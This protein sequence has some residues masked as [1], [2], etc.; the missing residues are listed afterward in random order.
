MHVSPNTVLREFLR[1][2]S[3]RPLRNVGRYLASRWP[4]SVPVRLGARTLFVD[5]RSSIGRGIY[6]TGT[7]DPVVFDPIRAALRP[8]GVFLDVGANIGYY[9]LLALDCVGAQGEV[10]AFEIDPRPLRCLRRTKSLNRADNLTIHEIAVGD[11]E[12]KAVLVPGHDCGH[13]T[14]DMTGRGSTVPM[15]SL[16]AI[17]EALGGKRVQAIKIDVEGGE[18]RVLE[19]ARGVLAKERPTV[20]CELVDEH[21][22]AHGSSAASVRMFF[23]DV[24]Y[25]VEEMVG[26]HTPTIVAHPK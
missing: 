13:T 15:R 19:G 9:S 23:A 24:R 17:V 12:G 6:V 14:V 26:V 8:G 20:I 25:S 1:L 4:W 10:H 2:P 22:R 18:M 7:F 11:I 16:D 5:L 3:A 21:L